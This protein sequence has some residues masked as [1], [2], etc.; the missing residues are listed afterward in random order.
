MNFGSISISGL[1]LTGFDYDAVMAKYT[2]QH[3]ADFCPS[4]SPESEDAV[5][6]KSGH[7]T[8]KKLSIGHLRTDNVNHGFLKLICE[9]VTIE[10]FNMMLHC[11]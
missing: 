3:N 6:I 11:H 5:V 4:L 1:V 7:K 2:H 10:L 8:H 9:V